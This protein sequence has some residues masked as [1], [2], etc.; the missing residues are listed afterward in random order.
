[1]G[2]YKITLTTQTPMMI[3]GVT[4]DPVLDGA[5]AMKE[6]RP[7]ITASAFKG[8]LRIVFE[9]LMSTLGVQSCGLD[10]DTDPVRS[11]KEG[12][13]EC[14]TCRLFGGG[15]K[16]G[17]L[18][19]QDL[20]GPRNAR[21][22]I[23][24]QVAISR[25][26]GRAVEKKLFTR[27][28]VAPETTFE[29][30]IQV[31]KP[32]TEEERHLWER[33]LGYLKETGLAIGG[34][35]S[36]GM[37]RVLFH[38]EGPQE[39]PSPNLSV[40]REGEPWSFFEVVLRFQEPLHL[41][42]RRV[43]YVMPTL[44]YIPGP[45]LRGALAFALLQAG[46]SED[47]IEKLFLKGIGGEVLRFSNF[48]LKN[49]YPNWAT[50]RRPKG[51]KR[52]D[53]RDVLISDFLLHQVPHGLT[54]EKLYHR[55][56][57]EDVPLEPLPP[58]PGDPKLHL[59]TRLAIHRKTGAA[60]KE[61]LYT[62]EALVPGQT[63]F[64]FYGYI[65]APQS[66]GTS[67][68]NLVLRV[69]GR[70]TK[71]FGKGSIEDLS[72]KDWDTFESRVTQFNQELHRQAKDNGIP[73]PED[74]TYFTIDFLSEVALPQEETLQGWLQN[75]FSSVSGFQVE[76]AWLHSE[77]R[78]GFDALKSQQGDPTFKPRQG[79]IGRGSVVLLSVPKN[80]WED[81][82]EILR[83]LLR[84]GIGALTH[85]GFGFFTICHEAHY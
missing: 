57:G 50:L 25:R 85:E 59:F 72:S 16:P 56:F 9:T 10:S 82:V 32:L 27:R 31:M 64:K 24:T 84:K 19:F 14:I 2:K 12:C 11:V 77:E 28:F 20:D 75:A 17:K 66:W 79:L 54:N 35:K 52:K 41:G 1:M 63:S 21:F 60:H 39:I 58:D 76:R 34:S 69:G 33:F 80:Q 7:Y 40:Y 18:R 71:G 37:G 3:G 22:L 49:P 8:A 36:T 55:V 23:R 68:R 51:E 62:L 6:N 5:T 13:G 30:E 29:G 43:R 74:R 26:T 61:R 38:Y 78:G 48:Y 15:G 83:A 73:L 53:P 42:Y 45:T 67:L 46:V 70:T 44:R 81:A 47:E 65:R 4:P